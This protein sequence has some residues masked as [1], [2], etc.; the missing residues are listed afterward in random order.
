MMLPT[1][2]RNGCRRVRAGSTNVVLVLAWVVLLALIAVGSYIAVSKLVSSLRA[3]KS[4]PTSAAAPTEPERP[5]PTEPTI[6][7]D[8]AAKKKAEEEARQE[9]ERQRLEAERKKQEE[10]KRLA[11]QKEKDRL[12]KI[13][14][15]A[16]RKKEEQERIAAEKLA[17]LK[18]NPSAAAL[19]DVE[20]APDRYLGQFLV[21]DRVSIKLAT[22][23]RHKELGRYTIAVTSQR[24]TVYSRVPLGGLVVSTSDKVAM[25]MLKQIVG[26]A[27]DFFRFK[28]YCEIRQWGKKDGTRTW[29]EVFI[30]RLEAYDNMGNMTRVMEE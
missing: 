1:K 27:D 14:Q 22:M 29:P 17:K 4:E 5:V 9:A 19:E 23:D 24:G 20:S 28:L 26:N 30:Y 10:A 21:F 11:E 12:D 25:L 3:P 13:A 8:T 18:R 15:E 16:Q 6:P 7:D 2:Y